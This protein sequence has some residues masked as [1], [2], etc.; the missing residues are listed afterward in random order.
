M[1]QA[2]VV[3]A[4]G[5]RLQQPTRWGIDSNLK[6]IRI[7]IDPD[8]V[9]RSAQ[10]KPGETALIHG[11]AGGVGTALGGLILLSRSSFSARNVPRER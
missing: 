3:L 5:T 2:D 1:N 4:V 10:A 8:E 9:H 11:A 6:L 7:E